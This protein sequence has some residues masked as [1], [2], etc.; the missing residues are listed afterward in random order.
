MEI[1]TLPIFAKV[2]PAFI[3]LLPK[4]Q[5]NAQLTVDDEFLIQLNSIWSKDAGKTGYTNQPRY[6]KF[7]QRVSFD[8]TADPIVLE[9]EILTT[10][11]EHRAQE[12]V[13][14][15]KDIKLFWSGGIDSTLT[16]ASILSIARTDQIELYHTCES[17]KENPY[18]YDYIQKFNVRTTMW[19]DRWDTK[20]KSDDLIVTGTSADE[21]TGSL[22]RSFYDEHSAGLNQPWQVFFK[23]KGYND[24][25]I[26]RCEQLFSESQSPIETMF[27]AR[28]WFYFYIRHT[29]YARRD[30]D[31]NL[32]NDFSN[33][34]VQFFNCNTFDSWAILNK[35]QLIHNEY[36]TYKQPF[37]EVIYKYWDNKEFLHNKEKVNSLLSTHWILKKLARFDQQYLFVYKKN[38]EYRT[39]RPNQYPFVSLQ[40]TLNSLKGI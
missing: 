13:N 39:F 25:F 10:I 31:Y 1:L 20:F 38:N 35:E 21:I 23:T 15:N 8:T 16:V 9:P 3:N 28:W 40:D 18:F 2:T 26:T 7:D 37:K 27:D 22:D 30:W 32:E 29:N 17:I 14:E 12:I 11:V 33:N 34:V 24:S 19:S 4:L 5:R 36:R 6:Y